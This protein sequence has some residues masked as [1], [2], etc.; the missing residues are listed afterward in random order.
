MK[1]GLPDFFYFNQ[2]SEYK[3]KIYALGKDHIHILD[4]KNKQVEILKSDGDYNN[5]DY[6][7]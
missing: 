2:I 7:N 4:L 6:W 5:E 1:L 3:G